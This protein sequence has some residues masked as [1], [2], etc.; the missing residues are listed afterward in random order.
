MAVALVGSAV[1]T[2][3]NGSSLN[4]NTIVAEAA[5][6]KPPVMGD[7]TKNDD[8]FYYNFYFI[9]NGEKNCANYYY[10]DSSFKEQI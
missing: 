1:T 9:S 6:T 5:E 10:D 8:A 4:D 3:Y 2:D 7:V